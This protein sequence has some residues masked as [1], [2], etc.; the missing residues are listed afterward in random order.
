MNKRHHT[1]LVEVFAR[2]VSGSIK[3]TDVEALFTALGARIRQREGSRV[4]V[5]LNDEKYIF[6]RPHPRPTMDKAAIS[7]IRIWLQG[8]G[9]TP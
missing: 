4:A 8:M 2:P 9:I 1:T 5:L 3:W 6:H 7:A